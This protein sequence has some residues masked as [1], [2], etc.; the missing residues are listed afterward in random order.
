MKRRILM[1]ICLTAICMQIITGSLVT[2]QVDSLARVEVSMGI[3]LASGATGKIDRPKAF[4]ILKKYAEAGNPRAMNGLGLMYIQGYISDPDTLQAVYWLTKAAENGFSPAWNNLGVIYKYAH[5]GIQQDLEKTFV[6]FEKA[7][8]SGLSDG[9]YNA[10]YM[11]Y[12]GLGCEQNYEKAYSYFQ[13][14][15]EMDYAP[16]MYMLGLCYR[17]G[18]G[19]ACSDGDAHFWLAKADREAYKFATDEIEAETPEN[20]I[21]PTQLR[22]AQAMNIPPKFAKVKH[23]DFGE[24]I[25]GSFEGLLVTYDWSGKNIIRETPL[26]LNLVSD[27]KTVEGEWIEASDTV[28]LKAEK[29]S[30]SLRFIDMHH[31]R[32]DHYNNAN[33]PVLFRFE[34]AEMQ[35]TDDGQ[36]TTL[37][38]NI[39]MYSPESMEPERP[40]YLSLQKANAGITN[41]TPITQIEDLR[42]YPIPFYHELNISFVQAEKELVKIGIYNDLGACVYLYDAGRL[43]EG[44]QHLILSPL[45]PAGTY[46]VKLFAG[47]HSSQ[48]IVLSNGK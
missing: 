1:K 6:Y 14:G 22:S 38:G 27:G 12:K 29:E 32:N 43:P 46:I 10:G 9:Y 44:E 25:N 4:E 11:L 45:L 18:Y 7:A 21:S 36:E 42:V 5:G 17:N 48:V 35:I 28:L 3:A 23:L 39:R 26:I 31:Y 40:M 33:D 41:I 19:V 15:A 16:A 8:Q 47:K 34:Q 2:A 13:K 30:G 24:D 20:N 37:I